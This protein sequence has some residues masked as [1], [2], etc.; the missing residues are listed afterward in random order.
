MMILCADDSRI[1]R[2]LIRQSVDVLGYE[3]LEAADGNEAVEL[4][5]AN[6][7]NLALV[8]LD[9]NMPGRNGFEVLELLKGLPELKHV[10]VMMVTTEGE[11]AS[12]VR[13]IKAGAKHYVTKPFS[14]DDLTVKMLECLGEG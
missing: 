4:A 11:K 8:L 6:A 9:V 10:P 2:R 12:I 13:A 3:F 1:M 5:Q 14:Q 7:D